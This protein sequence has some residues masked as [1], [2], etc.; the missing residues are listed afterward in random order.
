MKVCYTC[1][2]TKFFDMFSRNKTKKDGYQCQCKA[3]HKAYL[4][5][6]KD[7]KAAMDKAYY[8]TNKERIAAR[9]KAYKEANKERY[10]AYREANKDK[11]AER[12]KAYYEAN[13]E[14]LAE[15]KKAYKEAN[16]ER[17]AELNKA[18]K[19][20]NKERIAE[21]R[22][23]HYEANKDKNVEYS[24]RRRAIQRKAIPKFLR[25]CEVERK[26]LQDTYKLRQLISEA[27]GI[28]HHVDHMWPLSKGGP[29]WSGNL[30]IITAT[31]NLSKKDKLCKITKK[32]I[33]D[34][35]RIA[36]EEY[37]NENNCNGHRD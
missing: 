18:Y 16:K 30:Q 8:E 13:K 36:K 4:E 34:S 9:N 10:K 37:T 31:E 21:Y 20:A 2:E 19:K 12:F 15:H 25:N 14:R 1:K 29:H 32:N 35:L 5:A 24:N 3:C 26:R 17:L 6:N 27:T 7:K 11:F 22:K 33:K 28:E 23:A